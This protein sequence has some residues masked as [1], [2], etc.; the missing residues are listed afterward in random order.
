MNK[1]S[2]WFELDY[3]RTDRMA[4]IICGALI[5]SMANTNKIKLFQF[6]QQIYKQCGIS[7]SQSDHNFKWLNFRFS[8][9][10]F[11]LIQFSISSIGFFIFKS[12]SIGQSGDSFYMFTT[13]VAGMT[14]LIIT[15]TKTDDFR[16]FIENCE[17][18]IQ[19]S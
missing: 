10:S 18:F 16:K 5:V 3:K 14:H 6:V 2:I 4:D 9:V 11:V 8:L 17:A 15:I 12:T 13:G 19:K 1:E 7:T